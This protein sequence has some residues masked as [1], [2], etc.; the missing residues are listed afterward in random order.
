MR[1]FFEINIWASVR[2]PR[3]DEVVRLPGYWNVIVWASGDGEAATFSE[4]SE[5]ASPEPL[6]NDEAAARSAPTFSAVLLHIKRR[7]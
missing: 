2:S 1:A 5:L 6:Y 3:A 4:D 7:A